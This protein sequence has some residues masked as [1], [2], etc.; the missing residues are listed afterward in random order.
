M[1]HQIVVAHPVVSLLPAM[2]ASIDLHHQMGGVAIEIHDV[3]R[4]WLLPS[5]MR[6]E[7]IP[8]KFVPYD[9]LFESHVLSQFHRTAY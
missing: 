1:P 4:E 7:S 6:A 8:A 3:G 9:A 5:E 2:R